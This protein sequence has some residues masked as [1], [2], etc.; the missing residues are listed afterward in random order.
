MI[1]HAH[2][3]KYMIDHTH[4]YMID[5]MLLMEELHILAYSSIPGIWRKKCCSVY[6]HN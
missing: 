2:I 5:H 1:D 4:I 6:F 3:N